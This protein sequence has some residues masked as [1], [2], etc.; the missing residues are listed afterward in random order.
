MSGPR[1][2]I[3]EVGGAMRTAIDAALAAD[4]L[5]LGEARVLLA[6][7]R[8]VA[9]YSRL[10]DRVA[11]ARLSEV[12]R[13]SE[14]T[15]SSALAR[16][17]GDV[18]ALTYIASRGR[19]KLSTVGVPSAKTGSSGLRVST[20][21]EPVKR[22]AESQKTGSPGLRAPEKT[23]EETPHAR[24]RATHRQPPIVNARPGGGEG[25][26]PTSRLHPVEDDGHLAELRDRLPA[27]IARRIPDRPTALLTA[28]RRAAADGWTPGALARHVLAL[29]ADRGALDDAD[30][31]VAALVWRIRNAGS[32]PGPRRADVS[33][34]PAC[35]GRGFTFPD[36]ADAAFP[37]PSCH[38]APV[39]TLTRH[40]ATGPVA[41]VLLREVSA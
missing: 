27:R 8:E 39:E 13:V 22:E 35:D 7:L 34:C 20:D 5:T 3:V 18:G 15:V 11:R 23:S 40:G 28:C 25:G 21:D 37:C 30:D 31:P 41:D 26:E 38:P 24:P 19:G 6:V 17:S 1:D 33:P 12:A 16:L 36:D 14:R 10:S 4:D 32:P 29:D 2:S 9:T